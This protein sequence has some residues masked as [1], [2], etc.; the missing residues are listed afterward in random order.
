MPTILLAKNY[1][2]QYYA[3]PVTCGGGGGGGGAACRQVLLCQSSSVTVKKVFIS[4]KTSFGDELG[5]SL[6]DY[7]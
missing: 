1:Y 2:A 4:L 6:K 7:H 5:Q 3:K